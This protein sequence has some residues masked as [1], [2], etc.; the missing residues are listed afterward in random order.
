MSL[1]ELN[2]VNG[3]AALAGIHSHLLFATASRPDHS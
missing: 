2:V 3:G 1:A